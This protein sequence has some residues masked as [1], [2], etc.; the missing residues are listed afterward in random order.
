MADLDLNAIKAHHERTLADDDQLTISEHERG[1]LLAEVERLYV[2]V[3]RLY[4]DAIRRKTEFVDV[5]AEREKQRNRAD[6]AETA[7]I[8][9]GERRDYFA[10]R[11]EQQER[12]HAETVA[13]VEKLRTAEQRV[14]DLHQRED[15]PAGSVCG[16]CRDA[17]EEPVDW[18][19]G[20]IYRL[21]GW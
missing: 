19:C 6:A 4:V 13:E 11:C 18:P 20:T 7:L 21:D 9:A 10:A 5:V 15:G 2:E 12:D 14:R 8:A 1:L 17:Y 3:E 16:T